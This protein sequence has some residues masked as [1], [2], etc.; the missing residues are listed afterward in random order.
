MTSP[1]EGKACK[2]GGRVMGIKVAKFGG[3]SVADGIQLTKTKEIIREDPDRKYIVVSAPR[4][5]TSFTCAKRISSTICRT[6]SF[7]RSLW[8]DTWR[9]KST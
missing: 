1:R 3:S 9:L 5:P 4:S 8:T 2:V 6:T 7:F